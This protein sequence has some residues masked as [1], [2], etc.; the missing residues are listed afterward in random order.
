MHFG[1]LAGQQVR[2][3]LLPIE[4]LDA[5]DAGACAHREYRDS[6]RYDG[7]CIAHPASLDD[8]SPYPLRAESNRP[9]ALCGGVGC[10]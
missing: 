7:N 1:D 6:D 4:R 8:A 3:G 10:P 5:A 2:V 9:R